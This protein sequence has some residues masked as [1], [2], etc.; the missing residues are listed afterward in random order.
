MINTSNLSVEPDQ[1]QK[2]SPPA[3]AGNI[4]LALNHAFAGHPPLI[5]ARKRRTT[6]TDWSAL[7]HTQS[8]EEFSDANPD[9]LAGL[10]HP[11]EPI[12]I[13]ISELP[14]L[15]AGALDPGQL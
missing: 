13:W 6:P 14:N 9:L 3:N 12:V 15:V 10:S 7:R 1:A 4:C 2:D 11:V 8:V 5:T